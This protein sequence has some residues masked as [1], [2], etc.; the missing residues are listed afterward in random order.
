V[1]VQVTARALEHHTMLVYVRVGVAA[2]V[3]EHRIM[4]V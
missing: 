2:R 1:R 4:P 3:L